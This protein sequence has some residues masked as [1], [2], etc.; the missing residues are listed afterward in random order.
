M[1][2][3]W[4]KAALFYKTGYK[5]EAE[6]EAAILEVQKDLF[7]QF[8]IYLNAKRKTGQKG[9][10]RNIPD[11]YLLDLSGKR[12]RLYVI[13]V[14]LA[15]HDPLRHIAVQILQ[16]S[17][18]FES[19]PRVVKNILF[20]AIH[21]KPQ[22][23]EQCRAYAESH[24]FRN[25]DHLLDYLVFEADFAALVIIDEMP[26]NLE[27]VL[28]EKFAFGVEILTVACYQSGTGDRQYAFEPFLEDID[29]TREQINIPV[30][31][32]LIDT[33]EIDTIVVPARQEGFER[34]FLGENCWYAIRIHGS[35][36]PQIKYIAGYQVAPI[37][38]IT[39][40]A[41]VKS[42]QPWKIR[43]SMW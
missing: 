26:D 3:I 34:V 8:R 31:Q 21:E 42:I 33:T 4:S 32:T 40:I 28:A 38:S 9:G 2:V 13:E 43:A 16:F 39:H 12:P 22:I 11:G 15:V 25:L 18:S 19:E 10:V 14:E 37:S 5:T 1:S 35:M 6:L 17:L 24:E 30:A 7:G 27:T 23:A 29:A 41:P 36:R 20:D